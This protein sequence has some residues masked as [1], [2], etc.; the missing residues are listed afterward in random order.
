MEK[1]LEDT[2]GKGEGGPN[3]E[4][5][6]ETYTLLYVKWIASGD[7]LYDAGNSNPVLCDNLKEWDGV[8][9]GRETQEE[10]DMYIP[11]ADSCG[12]MAGTNTTL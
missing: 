1:R 10:G 9:V 5:G 4:S 6:V 7:L 3:W 12:C 8:G 2:V 11:M